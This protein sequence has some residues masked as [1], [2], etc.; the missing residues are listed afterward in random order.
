MRTAACRLKPERSTA[1]DDLR[2]CRACVSSWGSNI[3]S[4]T[5]PS[6]SLG[7]VTRVPRCIAMPAHASSALS[8]RGSLAPSSLSASRPSPRRRHHAP[9][10][11][12]TRTRIFSSAN[13]VGSGRCC[14]PCTR[15][16]R[17][18]ERLVATI[19]AAAAHEAVR[20]DAAPKVPAQLLLDV[21][22]QSFVVGLPRPADERLEVLPHDAVEHRLRR[23]SR[24]IRRGERGHHR[25][26]AIC[27]PEVQRCS[28]GVFFACGWPGTISGCPLTVGTAPVAAS[29]TGRRVR[30]GHAYGGRLA[31]DGAH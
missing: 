11:C 16:R 1:P 17:T 5:A 14:A 19:V 28:L 15:T 8:A 6:R 26:L 13:S 21:P 10:R 12:S 4:D 2:A 24:C 20:K 18:Q 23:A 9:M 29:C 25:A 3:S 31:P 30:A 27:V 22:G 7:I